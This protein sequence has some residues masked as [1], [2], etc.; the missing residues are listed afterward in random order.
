[1]S[2][3]S[4]ES[5]G[6]AADRI[7]PSQTRSRRGWPPLLLAFVMC[8]ALVSLAT[9]CEPEPE[10]EP[11][12]WMTEVPEGFVEVDPQ[13]PHVWRAVAADGSAVGVRYRANEEAGALDFWVEV[14]EREMTLGKGYRLART[15][16]VTSS[17]GVAGK[18]L[19][20]ELA[21]EDRPYH[22]GLAIYVTEDSIVTVE[23]ATELAD[24]ERYT[25][26]FD[27]ARSNVV[28]A[29]REQERK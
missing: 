22:Y 4:D 19:M 17:D 12:A 2:V 5:S 28:V 9:K 18:V 20:L 11:P 16:E 29:V 14:F 1:M 15:T 23:T 13:R 25:P 6:S 24:L 7:T 27:K 21:E 3:R 8:F 10:E 26:V